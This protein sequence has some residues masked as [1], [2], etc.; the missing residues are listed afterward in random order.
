[1]LRRASIRVHVTFSL[2]DDKIAISLKNPLSPYKVGGL[3]WKDVPRWSQNN[4]TLIDD[5]EQGRTSLFSSSVT[6]CETSAYQLI[7]S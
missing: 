7:F 5:E 6:P 2:V 1:M 4:K 3:R